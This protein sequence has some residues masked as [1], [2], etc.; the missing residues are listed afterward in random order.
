MRPRLGERSCSSVYLC[1]ILLLWTFYK[2]AAAHTVC[3]QGEWS[4]WLA[5]FFR[6]SLPHGAAGIPHSYTI[7]KDALDGAPIEEQQQFLRQLSLFQLPL[8]KQSLL[9][10]FNQEVHVSLYDRVTPRNLS[11][12]TH[13]TASPLM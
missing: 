6:Q 12:F 7:C 9:G 5:F 2:T 3:V 10:F 13:S 4:L 1:G 11:S 8:K